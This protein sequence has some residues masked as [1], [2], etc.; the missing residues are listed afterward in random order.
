MNL[1]IQLRYGF[2]FSHFSGP[3]HDP[4]KYP[5]WILL[6]VAFVS[7]FA[8]VFLIV[9]AF[10]KYNHKSIKNG[11]F[12]QDLKPNQ[13][14]TIEA[15]ICLAVVMIQRERIDSK[16]KM[17][18]IQ[19]HL[20]RFFPGN[21]F[22]V[23]HKVSSYYKEK[24]IIVKTVTDWINS[25]TIEKNIKVNI[26]YF[27]AGIAS[28]DGE[29]VG[30][31]LNFL[32]EVNQLFLLSNADLESV[33]NSF[34]YQ[35]NKKRQEQ[36]QQFNSKM[37]S[38]YSALMLENAYKILGLKVGAKEEEIKSAY[39]N[40]AKLNHPDRFMNEDEAHQKIAHERFLKI[41]EA[42]EFALKNS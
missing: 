14:N 22:D 13:E 39:R 2:G 33:L 12:Q 27:L 25:N 42:Y 17:A 16:R 10:V 34:N 32:K 4:V 36:E 3:I 24:P 37:A 31:E 6:L 20:L 18:F 40:L 1:V 35:A 21:S 11:V 7:L 5:V 28:V 26:V 9:R 29:I 19:G 41:Q 8:P 30:N 23:Y 15:Y 38:N